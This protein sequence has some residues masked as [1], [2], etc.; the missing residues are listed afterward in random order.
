MNK[1]LEYWYWD[2]AEEFIIILLIRDKYRSLQFHS[3]TVA[4][5]LLSYHAAEMSDS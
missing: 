5:P 4:E 3:L 1:D 2:L